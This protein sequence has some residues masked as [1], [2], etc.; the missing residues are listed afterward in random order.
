MATLSILVYWNIYTIFIINDSIMN[1]Q[2]LCS[3]H[4][5]AIIVMSLTDH[6][7]LL[8]MSLIM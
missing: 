2:L 4:A 5:E 8:V 6:V 1:V 7:A 3:I